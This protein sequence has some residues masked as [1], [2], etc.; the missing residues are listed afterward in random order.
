VAAD[1]RG[2]SVTLRGKGSRQHLKTYRC[3]GCQQEYPNTIDY[4]FSVGTRVD[5]GHILDSLCIT[6]RNAKRQAH[7]TAQSRERRAIRRKALRS[8]A[9]LFIIDEHAGTVQAVRLVVES[10]MALDRF[11]SSA[12]I[13]QGVID[14]Y[15]KRGYR[16]VRLARAEKKGA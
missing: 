7:D 8:Q 15:K 2:S 16:V 5:G 4:F 3:S 11:N 9:K 12:K 6:C 1:E 10:E 13:R 14:T